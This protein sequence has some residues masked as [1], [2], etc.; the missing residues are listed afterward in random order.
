MMRVLEGKFSDR[1]LS[2]PESTVGHFRNIVTVCLHTF[3][4]LLTPAESGVSKNSQSEISE[5]ALL[6]CKL[7]S[8]EGNVSSV[9]DAESSFVSVKS[10]IV[11]QESLV[12]K[13]GSS[14]L[15]DM[16]SLLV[17]YRK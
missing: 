12:V 10:S 2:W 8:H 16:V 1:S 15:L 7:V 9:A 6:S 13:V 5:L 11:G 14:L 17:R 4:I 3:I